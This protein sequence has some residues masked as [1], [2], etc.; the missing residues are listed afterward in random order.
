MAKGVLNQMSLFEL[1]GSSLAESK[2]VFSHVVWTDR[3]S[4]EERLSQYLYQGERILT[5]LRERKSV[6]RYK[7]C[8]FLDNFNASTY[9]EKKH[10]GLGADYVMKAATRHARELWERNDSSD[11]ASNALLSYLTKYLY[12]DARN[13]ADDRKPDLRE[14]VEYF[15]R[16]AAVVPKGVV[17]VKSIYGDYDYEIP[18][19]AKAVLPTGK[20]L[21]QY[22][23]RRSAAGYYHLADAGTL[24]CKAL[25]VCALKEQILTALTGLSEKELSDSILYRFLTDKEASVIA[26]YRKMREY[27]ESNGSSHGEPVISVG[28]S[29]AD[30]PFVEKVMGRYQDMNFSV[31]ETANEV[32]AVNLDFFIL[33]WFLSENEK[34]ML[35]FNLASNIS[36]SLLCELLERVCDIYITE[37]QTYEMANALKKESAK[38]YQTKKNISLKCQRAMISSGFNEYFG[39]VEIDDECDLDKF[40]VVEQQFKSLSKL[41]FRGRKN[42][43]V[44]IRFRK[45]GRHHAAGLY[46]PSIKCLAVDVRN[47]DSLSHEYFHMLDHEYGNVSGGYMFSKVRERYKTCLLAALDKPENSEKK[48]FL[49]KKTKYDLNYYLTPTEV[50]ARCGELYLTKV[51]KV[52]NSLVKPDEE[53]SF[54]YPEDEKL[55]ELISAFFDEFLKTI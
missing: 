39:Y 23:L 25:L 10:V 12:V 4:E 42:A 11:V 26:T 41:L 53:L 29:F 30:K 13:V 20:H 1:M 14:L 47:T 18:A 45:L 19:G 48:E 8:D 36:T 16:K 33:S 32:S 3:I 55:I 34:D 9:L 51:K 35:P 46:F 6:V 24:F 27:Q 43:E 7:P 2:P 5:L 31:V 22:R 15:F 50:F 40:G 21:R 37:K 28:S 38:V 17:S 54:A 49:K 52:N 44:S